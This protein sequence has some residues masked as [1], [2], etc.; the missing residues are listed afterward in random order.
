MPLVVVHAHTSHADVLSVVGDV[1]LATAPRLVSHATDVIRHGG[2]ALVLDLRAVEFMDSA[3]L[4][5]LLNV[6]RRVTAVDGE[7]VLADVQP[8][9]RRLLHDTRVDQ[10][11]AITDTVQ[12]AE[13]RL[14]EAA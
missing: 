5:A 4:A 8:Q 7:L 6:L 3:G 11:F 13:R 14:A 2:R 1:D 10:H 12:D 9:A